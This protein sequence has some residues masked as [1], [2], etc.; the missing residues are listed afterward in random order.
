MSTCAPSDRLVQTITVNTPGVTPDLINLQL[1]NVMDEFFRRTSAWTHKSEITLVEDILDYGFVTPTDS[2][3]VRLMGVTHQN[4]PVPSAASTT[5]I[6]QNSVGTIEP[7]LLFPDGDISVAPAVSDLE[8][9]VFSYAIYR[10]NYISLTSLPDVEARKHPMEVLLALSL[11][12]Q[13]LECNCGDWA[14][15]EWM[16]DTYFGDWLD[17]VLSRLYGMPAKPWASTTHAVYHGKRFRN[18]MGTRKQEAL[19]GFTYNQPIWRFPTS[20]TR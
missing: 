1:F 10:P 2:V 3:V 19:R 7:E 5:G 11:A 18:A 13:C 12:N 6:V 8:G 14:V 17:G 20:W 16:W 4:I 15:D 9:G